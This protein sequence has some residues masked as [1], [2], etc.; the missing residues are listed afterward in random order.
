MPRGEDFEHGNYV[1][2]ADRALFV[3]ALAAIDGSAPPPLGQ[4]RTGT[5]LATPG[6]AAY[7][8]EVLNG[9]A[10]ISI[11]AA[12]MVRSFYLRQG[13]HV[14]DL[15]FWHSYSNLLT[16]AWT[17]THS[18]LVRDI[19]VVSNAYGPTAAWRCVTAGTSGANANPF[20]NGFVNAQVT[21]GTTRG[22]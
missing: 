6:T 9:H 1:T 16:P 11:G 14:L 13:R 15:H 21:D 18:Y 22:V 8:V 3:P 10:S 19:V 5:N 2:T 17:S 12:G 7:N 4:E 20:V